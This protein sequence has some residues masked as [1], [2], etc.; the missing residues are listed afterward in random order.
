MYI[1]WI[2]LLLIFLLTLTV[3]PATTAHQFAGCADDDEL[4]HAAR[5]VLHDV[6]D[7]IFSV[8][9][10]GLDDFDPQLEIRYKDTYVCQNDAPEGT[11]Y[12][13]DL[14]TAQAGFSSNTARLSVR[15]LAEEFPDDPPT[16][17]EIIIT[18]RHGQSGEFVMLYEGASIFGADD[19]DEVSFFTTDEQAAQG[20]RSVFYAANFNPAEFPLSPEISLVLGTDFSLTCSVS[21]LADLC[22]GSTT[23]LDDFTVT[24]DYLKSLELS[25]NDVM[26]TFTPNLGGEEYLVEIK[27]QDSRS[28][29]PYIFMVHGGVA[30][31]EE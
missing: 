23:P 4:E 3:I 28:Y 31:P 18:E 14:P 30:Y 22:D 5:F 16:D 20:M 27:S 13:V 19:V 7:T 8:T 17:F 15:F 21:S 26:L 10:I 2:A 9:V 29:G 11:F 25:G 12:G 1:R 6:Y 24:Y